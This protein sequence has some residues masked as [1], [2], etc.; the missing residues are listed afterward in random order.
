[1]M[2]CIKKFAVPGS[3]PGSQKRTRRRTE[4]MHL[5]SAFCLLNLL[6]VVCSFHV[7]VIN[8][9][10]VS[11]R[12]DRMLSRDINW[13]KRMLTELNSS[14]VDKEED[15]LIQV[16]KR[17]QKR[18]ESSDVW[19]H[20]G[21]HCSYMSQPWIGGLPTLSA[22]EEMS[23][24]N[25]RVHISIAGH[26]KPVFPQQHLFQFIRHIY[27]CCKLGVACQKIKGLQG[28][29][30]R[31]GHHNNL[32]FFVNSDVLELSIMRAELHLEISNPDR[33]EV[34]PVLRVQ[35]TTAPSA[36]S[37]RH[38]KQVKNGILELTLDIMFLF[39]M[40]KDNHHEVSPELTE[41][42]LTLKCIKHSVL[43]SCAEH[44]VNI[45]LAPFIAI[46]YN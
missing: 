1:M 28:R 11:S 40:L 17:R 5:A 12:T 3:Q 35:H 22:A 24:L 18:S 6:H 7:N 44:G 10:G 36:S 33:V 19:L 34:E 25:L 45:L 39:K 16:F 14:K 41:L 31:G 15:V 2:F 46:A 42:I 4:N 21:T 13:I 37:S 9:E 27:N 32:E 8:S 43:V 30:R 23:P 26:P 29:L 38:I 20:M